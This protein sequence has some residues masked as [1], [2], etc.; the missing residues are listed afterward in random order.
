[1]KVLSQA[2]I[3]N[4]LCWYYAENYA[5]IISIF[6]YQYIKLTINYQLTNYYLLN[7]HKIIVSVKL[8]L[9]PLMYTY[10]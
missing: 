6:N 7:H 10:A 1:M 4:L 2:T 9:N 5:G 3:V 8:K